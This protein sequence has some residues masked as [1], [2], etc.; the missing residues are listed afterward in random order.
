MTF[1]QRMEQ[2]RRAHA[3]DA[4]SSSSPMSTSMTVDAEPS[5]AIPPDHFLAQQGKAT[6]GYHAQQSAEAGPSSPSR[7][8]S[9][10][11]STSPAP[12]SDGL[13]DIARFL[14]SAGPLPT[15][16]SAATTAPSLSSLPDTSTLAGADFDIDVRSGFLPPQ[17]P[18]SRIPHSL[19]ESVW[20]RFLDGAREVGLAINGGGAAVDKQHRRRCR[21]WRR[22]IREEMPVMEELSDKMRQ[23]IRFAR[24][25]HVVLTFL[26]HY[27]LHSQPQPSKLA[28]AMHEAQEK[29]STNQAA[30]S[31]SWLA[32]ALRWR[33]GGEA[34]SSSTAPLCAEDIADAASLHS[35]SL[36]HYA[37]RLP[38]SISV[39]LLALSHQ[40]DLPPILTYADTVLWNWTFINPSAGLTPG[41]LRI[42]ETFSGTESEHHFFLTSLLIELQGVAALGLMRASL[43]ECF[44]ADELARRRVAQYLQRLVG[45]VGEL[46]QTLKDVRKACDPATFYWAIRPWFRGG[47]AAPDGGRGWFYP[48]SREEEY[49]EALQPRLFTGPSAGQSSLIHALDVF[50]DVDH[51]GVKGHVAPPAGH[52]GGQQQQRK[53]P[54]SAERAKGEGNED[55]TFMQRM[56]LYMPGQHRRFLTHLQS[57]AAAADEEERAQLPEEAMDI[58]LDS[59][60]K[61][62]E[63]HYPSPIRHL[64][65]SCPNA[66]THPLPKAYNAALSSLRSLR[67]EHMRVATLYIV[68]QARRP[69]PPEYAPLLEDQEDYAR[70]VAKTLQPQEAQA[71]VEGAKEMEKEQAGPVGTGGTDL[72]KF[73]KACRR[74][75]DEALLTAGP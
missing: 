61:R 51:A 4:E 46:E 53:G 71:I 34:A 22:A 10:R 42:V 56:Q 55:G 2:L 40:L 25:G 74:R 37:S 43:D 28:R 31:S 7:A 35:E 26:A 18:L 30:S 8:S 66:A 39:P 72:V 44:V 13:D 60:E 21:A 1:K 20:E 17:A 3:L 23:D 32:S 16:P 70:T 5:F 50:L 54:A 57:L 52:G 24:R 45:V 15:A 67:D 11:L 65:Q 27:Y 58:D 36:G 48:S 69:P 62:P 19:H 14:S 9:S 41:N 49:S 47:D 33:R 63:K 68:S 73:L 64:A 6:A 12:S 75:T 59:E 29:A 38:A